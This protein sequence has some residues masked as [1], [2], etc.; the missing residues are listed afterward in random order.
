MFYLWNYSVE[1]MTKAQILCYW[2]QQKYGVGPKDEAFF[3]TLYNLSDKDFDR[4][5]DSYC[6]CGLDHGS[7]K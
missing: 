5:L 7:G 3:S 4:A 6:D 1:K 2:I